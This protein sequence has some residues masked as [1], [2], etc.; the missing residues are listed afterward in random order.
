MKTKYIYEYELY[1]SKSCRFV[2]NEIE[3]YSLKQAEHYLKKL[4]PSWDIFKL[5]RK[6]V[7]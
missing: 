4:N 3:A 7:L 5:Q 2:S 6:V 1:H